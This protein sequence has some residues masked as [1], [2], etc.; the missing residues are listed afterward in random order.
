M[1]HN[2]T[3]LVLMLVAT[4]GCSKRVDDVRCGPGT[5]L[6]GSECM[7][8]TVAASPTTPTVTPSPVARPSVATAQPAA[9]IAPG[10][11]ASGDEIK[12]LDVK[13]HEAVA[14]LMRA[15]EE[16]V[17]LCADWQSCVDAVPSGSDL[18][19]GEY[20]QRVRACGPKKTDACK[21]ADAAASSARRQ[22]N[23]AT[24]DLAAAKKRLEMASGSVK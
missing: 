24:A 7:A 22:S 11:A 12:R 3:A 23:A 18:P 14:T 13:F 4:S 5:T 10:A 20:A 6:V 2:A 15:R 9:S 17:A 19:P 16:E 8:A 1:R 21:K